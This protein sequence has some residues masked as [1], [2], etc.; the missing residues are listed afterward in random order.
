[1]PAGLT[2]ADR[3]KVLGMAWKAKLADEKRARMNAEQQRSRATPTPLPG[4]AH[5]STR[6]AWDHA[7]LT[8]NATH[9]PAPQPQLRAAPAAPQ[10]VVGQADP[11]APHWIKLAVTDGMLRVGQIILERSEGEAL[12]F[13]LPPDAR[14]GQCLIVNLP[15]GVAHG[16]TLRVHCQPPPAPCQPLLEPCLP[17]LQPMSLQTLPQPAAPPPGP[18]LDPHLP[19]FPP[20]SLQTLS[21]PAALP[22]AVAVP[23]EPL[24]RAPELRYL[25]LE[26]LSAAASLT[27]AASHRTDVEHYLDQQQRLQQL[28]KQLQQLQ[29][30]QQQQQQRQQQQQQRQQ[31]QQQLQQLQ[32]QQRQHQHN[33]APAPEPAPAPAL[34]S[35]QLH[36]R[37]RQYQQQLAEVVEDQITWEEAIEIAISLGMSRRGGD[38]NFGYL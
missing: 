3:E 27:A 17:L 13:A 16:Q 36:H 19:L 12:C 6:V 7:T 33:A 4:G 23:P 11:A 31:Q 24:R 8:R 37:Q 26:L 9:A 28:Q 38:D 25:P 15:P 32:Q 34:A 29:Q 2:C 30:H 10:L 20:M 14:P 5:G 18:L 21:P 35:R 1:M 22:P